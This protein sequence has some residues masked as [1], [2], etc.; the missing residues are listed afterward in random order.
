MNK[1]SRFF[2]LFF[3][4]LFCKQVHSAECTN[5]QLQPVNTVYT[6]FSN[7]TVNPQ[8]V[9]KA[10]TNPGGCNFFLT[11]SYGGGG[12]FSNRRLASF[13]NTW[14][15][16]ITKDAA[17]SFH[18]K[19]LAQASSSN[20]V[21]TGS[22]PGGGNDTQVTVNFWA[23][24]LDLYVARPAGLYS[25]S[26]T[27]TLYRGTL[28]S[29]TQIG[30][31]NLT[32][33]ATTQRIVDISIVPTGS[34]F[35]VADT[36]EVLNFGQLAQGTTRSAD[37]IL[38]YNSGYILRASSAN[39][40]RLKHATLNTFVPYTIKFAGTTVNLTNSAATPVTINQGSGVSPANGTI[41][42]TVVTIGTIA[43]NQANGNYSDTI[44][45]TVQSP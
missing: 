18:L 41:F 44:T 38:K 26:F 12:T 5:M 9:V 23:E 1:F 35:N 43:A 33:L 10:N 17:G 15:L 3:F 4:L 19:T 40:S 16:R 31:Y 27:V 24:L 8:A 20:D 36:S 11:V 13:L 45:L 22:L 32:L 37:V 30:S 6:F 29:F 21:V 14:P 2:G 34:S 42:N 39:N 28:S 7:I 25:D